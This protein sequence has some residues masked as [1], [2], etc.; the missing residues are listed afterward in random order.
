MEYKEFR[1][2]IEDEKRLRIIKP[3]GV[4]RTSDVPMD[5]LNKKT[6]E[7]FSKWLAKGLITERGDI[8][9]LGSHLY[10]G[11]F[12]PDISKEFKEEF[13][14]VQGQSSTVLR[15]VLE[16][17]L[18]AREFANM[19]WEFIYY[20]D[21]AMDRGFLLATRSRLILARH[22]PL[23]IKEFE[24]DSGPLRILIVVSK[25]EQDTD[26][27]PM[28]IVNA[29][30]VIETIEEL[31][32]RLP[33]SIETDKLLQPTKRS[34]ADKLGEFQP[35]V[36]HFIGHGKY[37]KDGGFLALV[38]EEDPKTVRWIVDMDLADYFM[39]LPIRLIFLHA[40]EGAK[41]ESYEAFRGVA[42]QL[43]YQKVP[44]VVAMQY[45]VSNKEANRFT[46]KFY[47]SLSEGKPID[48]AVQ[49]GRLE[50]GM[51]LEELHFSSRAFGSPVVYLQSADGIIIAEKKEEEVPPVESP[52]LVTPYKVPCPYPDCP[53][54]VITDS[55]L[56]LKCRRD[57]MQCPQCGTVMAKDIGICHKCKYTVSRVKPVLQ[58]LVEPSLKEA[59][60]NGKSI[61][62]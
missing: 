15:L 17:E 27:T 62:R 14:K 5:D 45:K 4:S 29:N 51:Y 58:E 26:G 43:V 39:D 31:K 21:T 57:L 52:P 50:L 30:P 23:N 22:V 55:A 60:Y 33:D 47:E 36:L 24:P 54:Y 40:C 59:K 25:P 28:D 16:F 20:P 34:L 13:D 7:M 42:L 38:S 6:I 44:A 3:S 9:V 19:P 61:N 56:C 41:S 48:A 18:G 49:D 46:K 10:N 2:I 1:V 53:G 12:N 37:D 11:L 32:N 35:H 8:A